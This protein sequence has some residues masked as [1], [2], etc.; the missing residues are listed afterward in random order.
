MIQIKSCPSFAV[1][2][3]AIVLL[4]RYGFQKL[5]SDIF[6]RYWNIKKKIFKIIK[7]SHIKHLRPDVPK[8]DILG[9][10]R[11]HPQC[12]ANSNRC[13][14]QQYHRTELNDAGRPS[15]SGNFNIIAKRNVRFPTGHKF[16]VQHITGTI[17]M[18]FVRNHNHFQCHILWI[19]KT[20]G[21]GFK[22][23]R[24]V[25]DSGGCIQYTVFLA[26]IEF[27]FQQADRH[28]SGHSKTIESECKHID[29]SQFRFQ[30]S[31]ERSVDKK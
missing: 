1:I 6:L 27:W 18:S 4:N 8:L 7:R 29:E 9:S 10:R 15:L 5:K 19:T 28:T 22:R 31:T 14:R 13:E 12:E 23:E 26:K 20:Q 2:I 16:S 25:G 30:L 11:N 24:I 21:I 17:R 3:L